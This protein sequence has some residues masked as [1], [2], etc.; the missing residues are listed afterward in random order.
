VHRRIGL[1]EMLKRISM[2][3]ELGGRMCNLQRFLDCWTGENGWCGGS[4]SFDSFESVKGLTRQ[5]IYKAG[6]DGA[7]G[8]ENGR[9]W[10]KVRRRCSVWGEHLGCCHPLLGTAGAMLQVACFIARYVRRPSSLRLDG[11]LARFLAQCD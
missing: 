3:D 5:K 4:E 11:P 6:A 9:K 8:Q 10:A 1:C 7:R 2:E